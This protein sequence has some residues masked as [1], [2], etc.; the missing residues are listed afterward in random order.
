MNSYF[1]FSKK[2][3][4]LLAAVMILGSCND[5]WNEHYSFKETSSK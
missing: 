4:L 2:S 1:N 3:V 5:T